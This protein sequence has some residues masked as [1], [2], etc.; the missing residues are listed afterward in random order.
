MLVLDTGVPVFTAVEIEERKI[1]LIGIAL[2]AAVPLRLASLVSNERRDCTAMEDICLHGDA[3]ERPLAG[4]PGSAAK[5][6]N[7]LAHALA[8]QSATGGGV[9]FGYHVG[10]SPEAARAYLAHVNCCIRSV[11]PRGLFAFVVELKEAA[12]AS[13][14]PRPWWVS[15]DEHGPP[16]KV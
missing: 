2:A 12:E 13:K 10:A 11:F 7:G 6:F 1:L 14:P 3:L 15:H 16:G 5:L 8:A 9:G 4:G